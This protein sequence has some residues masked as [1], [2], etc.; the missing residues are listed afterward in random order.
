MNSLEGVHCVALGWLTRGIEDEA[1]LFNDWAEASAST[2]Q[3]V[4]SRFLV[5]AAMNLVESAEA[6]IASV[7]RASLAGG[8]ADT[9]SDE[10]IDTSPGLQHNTGQ[11]SEASQTQIVL[12]IP[13]LTGDDASTQA[14][15]VDEAKLLA[16]AELEVAGSAFADES[17][18]HMAATMLA[19]R[20]RVLSARAPEDVAQ[21]YMSLLSEWAAFPT[22][23]QFAR[24][25][26]LVRCVLDVVV[27]LSRPHV[28][29]NDRD[30]FAS[31]MQRVFGD[32]F[33]ADADLNARLHMAFR[34]SLEQLPGAHEAFR[35]NTKMAATNRAGVVRPPRRS[36]H[37]TLAAAARLQQSQGDEPQQ[38]QQE[39]EAESESVVVPPLA[40]DVP[41]QLPQAWLQPQQ[42]ALQWLGDAATPPATWP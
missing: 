37:V 29:L 28:G 40:S 36:R 7:M 31:Y 27:R 13:P 38:L 26:G 11:S 19:L 15:W 6:L 3:A 33:T 25:K 20:F 41:L 8:Y 17:Q 2:G 30:A 9:E 12:Y 32:W 42:T 16:A 14:S 34:K 39:P 1:R 4:P 18:D 35:S 22:A 21:V 24:L 5:E 10:L 23:W